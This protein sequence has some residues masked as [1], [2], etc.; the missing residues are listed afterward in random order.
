MKSLLSSKPIACNVTGVDKA[1]GGIR[2]TNMMK[3]PE[4]GELRRKWQ[5]ALANVREHDMPPQDAAK[6][7]TEAE[8]RT[9]MNWV[10]MIKFLSPE[11]PGPLR[12]PPTDE[13]RVR[14]H[15]A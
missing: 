14:Q 3:R 9:F 2:F 8:R 6:Q 4:A 15:T 12:D 13:G 10:G 11:D 1:K 7:P 5:I